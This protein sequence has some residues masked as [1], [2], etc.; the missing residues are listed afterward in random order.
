MPSIKLYPVSVIMVAFGSD[1]HLQDAVC[2][3]LSS[4]GVAVSL[5]IVDNG[6]E[7]VSE[8]ARDDRITVLS[9]GHNLGFVGG[10]NLAASVAKDPYLAFVN[11]DALVEPQALRSMVAILA[12]KPR[13][14][15]SGLVLL[16]NE[17]DV[18]N[19]AG[20]PVHY[21][22]ISWAGW[23]GVRLA[24]AELSDHIPA[25]SGAFF[26]LSRRVWNELGGFAPDYFAYGED[27]ELSLRAH[28][29]NIDVILDPN[30][31]AYHHY[32]F[33]RNP[34][35]YFLL[36]RNRIAT[37]LTIYQM[38]TLL[39]LSP[40]LLVVEVAMVTQ[41]LLGGWF[42]QKMLSYINVVRAIPQIAQRRSTLRDVRK[43]SDRCLVGV[44]HPNID[45]PGRFGLTPPALLNTLLRGYWKMV[46]P[47]INRY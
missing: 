27:L 42:G 4:S 18:I 16:A 20:N 23:Y 8:L 25:V 10:C 5:L 14:I 33:A 22:F 28:L 44:L 15:V 17:K 30:S 13:I 43:C 9:P 36:E 41:S 3:I 38:R 19:S 21:S 45:P 11:N 6:S 34:R 1:K 32:D 31:R 2:A 39:L 7:K 40:A 46:A 26:G 47:I 35:K 24:E 37:L 12:S 29:S